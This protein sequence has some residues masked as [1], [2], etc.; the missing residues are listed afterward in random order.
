MCLTIGSP[1]GMEGA[2]KLWKSYCLHT[3]PDLLL[4]TIEH[5]FILVLSLGFVNMW[6][7][8]K[9]TWELHSD[10][11]RENACFICPLGGIE[12]GL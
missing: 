12:E 9:M 11:V 1:I 4:N 10:G 5:N 3:L 8:H 2:R 6:E 7:H